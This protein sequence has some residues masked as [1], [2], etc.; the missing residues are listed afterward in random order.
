MYRNEQL[1]IYKRVLKGFSVHNLSFFHPFPSISFFYKIIF[2][3]V[4]V[5]VSFLLKHVCDTRFYVF[6]FR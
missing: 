2:F 1:S 6:L 3:D 4:F 5:F